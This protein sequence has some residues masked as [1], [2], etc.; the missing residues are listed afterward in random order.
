MVY[1][2]LVNKHIKGLNTLS[3]TADMLLHWVMT[4]CSLSLN[5]V[6]LTQ[7]KSIISDFSQSSMSCPGPLIHSESPNSQKWPCLLVCNCRLMCYNYY[8][9]KQRHLWWKPTKFVSPHVQLVCLFLF[10]ANTWRTVSMSLQ[11]MW[12]YNMSSKTVLLWTVVRSW[13]HVCFHRWKEE[14]CSRVK[15]LQ[16]IIVE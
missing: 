3:T 13:L 1:L 2:P 12:D 6:Y 4:V 5:C 7:V 9:R 8:C 14:C 10:E 16:L 15:A 11:E